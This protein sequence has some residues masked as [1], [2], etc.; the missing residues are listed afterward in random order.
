M[1]FKYTYAYIYIYI[2]ICIGIFKIH[3]CRGG[4]EVN[5]S[6][7]GGAL[8]PPP[9]GHPLATGLLYILAVPPLRIQAG[10]GP[11]EEPLIT[12]DSVCIHQRNLR[13]LVT[14]IYRTRMN[15]SPPFMKEIFLER[16]IHYNLRATNN[17]YAHKP[18]TTTY[19]LDNVSSLGQNLWR[20][21]QWHVKES[22]TVKHIKKD[23]KFWN[24]TC[25][26]R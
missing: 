1:N 10:Y 13:L 17:I 6:S 8:P 14:E 2:Y 25:N 11:A 26:S 22:L 9:P 21:L 19:G 20:D 7:S 16:E 4:T 3:F 12:D 5:F 18:R 15:L 23:I 24:F